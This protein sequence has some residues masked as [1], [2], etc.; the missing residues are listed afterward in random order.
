MKSFTA[1]QDCTG[2]YINICL[3]RFR[4]AWQLSAGAGKGRLEAPLWALGA[5]VAPP[6]E[7]RGGRG[8]KDLVI[9]NHVVTSNGIEPRSIVS[10]LIIILN[11]LASISQPSRIITGLA[12]VTS[13][14]NLG[15]SG[16]PC[17]SR[18]FGTRAQ[19][20]HKPLQHRQTADR[21]SLSKHQKGFYARGLPHS[22]SSEG[23]GPHAWRNRPRNLKSSRDL[24]L[25]P[26]KYPCGYA[27]TPE[28]PGRPETLPPP[29]LSRPDPKTLL[30]VRHT[31]GLSIFGGGFPQN[32]RAAHG[33]GR[34]D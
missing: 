4:R 30:P 2:A 29:N 6:Q 22:K 34:H 20:S 28:N 33:P 7:G 16:V 27:G 19:T 8:G 23:R 13:A 32:P 31:G 1:Q 24:W 18:A 12:T 11:W 26:Q 10:L 3:R 17:A 15:R 21:R 9:T 25:E 5:R 14:A